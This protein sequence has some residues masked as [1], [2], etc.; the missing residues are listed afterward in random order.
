MKT[1]FRKF[2]VALP[3]GQEEVRIDLSVQDQ[4]SASACCFSSIEAHKAIIFKMSCKYLACIGGILLLGAVLSAQSPP[5]PNFI[6]RFA[7]GTKRLTAAQFIFRKPDGSYSQAGASG[8]ETLGSIRI[9][10][11][12]DG[13]TDGLKARVWT[14]GCAMEAFDVP[15]MD[16]DV[17]VQFVCDPVTTVPLRGRVVDSP[18]STA[19][20]AQ[21]LGRCISAG[22]EKR[23]GSQCLLPIQVATAKL[24]TDGSFV[25]DLPD[26]KADPVVSSDSSA[27]FKFRVRIADGSWRFVKPEGSKDPSIAVASSYSEDMRFVPAN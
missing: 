13:P 21:Y 26:F 12:T 11:L 7:D 17:E 6:I 18:G 9:P 20:A 8:G 19:I 2:H 25:I 23:E 3:G 22:I 1:L 27:T 4:T 14:P 10:K 16:A 5:G 15:L 24:E